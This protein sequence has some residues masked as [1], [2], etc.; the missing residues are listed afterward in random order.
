M[1]GGLVTVGRNFVILCGDLFLTTT[2]YQDNLIMFELR[3]Q[4]KNRCYIFFNSKAFAQFLDI[5]P[6]VAMKC[7][8]VEDMIRAQ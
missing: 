2:I 3:L 7:F 5:L 6:S 8:A 4:S 1:L